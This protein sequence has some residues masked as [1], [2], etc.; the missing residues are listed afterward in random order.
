MYHILRYKGTRFCICVSTASQFIPGHILLLSG[1]YN[2]YMVY[3]EYML[4]ISPKYPV[5]IH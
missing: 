1:L 4:F 3:Y 5:E 2:I